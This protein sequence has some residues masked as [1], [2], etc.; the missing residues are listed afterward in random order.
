MRWQEI[1][2]Y[3]TKAGDEIE[4][5]Y[6]EDAEG[7]NNRGWIVH[8]IQAYVNNQYAGYIAVSYIPKDRFIKYYPTILNYMSQ[9]SGKVGILPYEKRM[10]PKNILSIIQL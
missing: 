3:Q 10:M 8:E 2:E 9:I 4:F 5:R 7:D 6:K 1:I